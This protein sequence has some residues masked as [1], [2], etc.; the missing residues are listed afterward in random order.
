MEAKATRRTTDDGSGERHEP[1]TSGAAAR[2]QRGGNVGHVGSM[3]G[4]PDGWEDE[5]NELIRAEARRASPVV[6]SIPVVRAPHVAGTVGNWSLDQPD[7]VID[8][9]LLGEG[10]RPVDLSAVVQIAPLGRT[11]WDGLVLLLRNAASRLGRAEDHVALHAKNVSDEFK[12]V[13]IKNHFTTGLRSGETLDGPRNAPEG[14]DPKAETDRLQT[15]TKM[16]NA[17]QAGLRSGDAALVAQTATRKLLQ[18][19][20]GPFVLVLHTDLYSKAAGTVAPTSEIEVLEALAEGGSVIRSNSLVKANA[21]TANGTRGAQLVAF[22][23]SGGGCEIVRTGEPTLDFG[24]YSDE[25]EPV[26][27]VRSH[28]L[29]RTPIKTAVVVIK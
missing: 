8:F 18:E 13:R 3:L 12:G 21:P 19:H 14:L 11:D 29:L 9:A 1:E 25:G 2:A 10:A 15:V 4:W 26:I 20:S 6:N 17:G 5:L 24:G 27:R 7:D 28:F 22:A 16:E 23:T